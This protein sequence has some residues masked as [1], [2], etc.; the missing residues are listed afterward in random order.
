MEEK[1]GAIKYHVFEKGKA[2]QEFSDPAKAGAAWHKAANAADSTV[3]Y[4]TPEGKA[5]LYA[6]AGS[7]RG[8]VYKNLPFDSLPGAEEFKR[9][10]KESL[11]IEKNE[12]SM[13]VSKADFPQLGKPELGKTYEG[14]IVAMRNDMVIQAV[15]DGNRTHHVEHQ[16]ANLQFSNPSQM[17]QG[18]DVAIKYSFSANVGIVGERMELKAKAHEIQPKGLGGIGKG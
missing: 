5:K 11:A 15:K 16:R 3:I 2:G 12:L 4:Q 18:K 9:G 10:F 14:P 6:D 8:Q 17:V 7:D 13:P 1:S